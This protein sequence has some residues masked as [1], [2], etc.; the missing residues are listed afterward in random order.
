MV[1]VGGTKLGIIQA[2]VRQARQHVRVVG[3][4][5]YGVLAAPNNVSAGAR[6]AWVC[7]RGIHLLTD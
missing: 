7:E 1:G 4:G 2:Q 3:E 5:I 6:R